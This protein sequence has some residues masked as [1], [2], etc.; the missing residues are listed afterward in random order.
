LA[1]SAKDGFCLYGLGAKW[2]L[3]GVALL[4]LSALGDND[5]CAG[6]FGQQKDDQGGYCN[7]QPDEK[8]KA[9]AQGGS[10]RKASCL[11]QE[12]MGFTLLAVT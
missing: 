2:A 9:N 8:P 5:C 7:H 11:E 10:D 4:F 1:E 12:F 6:S 3:L